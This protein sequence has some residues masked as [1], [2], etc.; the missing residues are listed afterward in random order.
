MPAGRA[1]CTLKPGD[2][3][4]EVRYKK[5]RRAEGIEKREGVKTKTQCREGR[6]GGKGEVNG[7]N[8][9]ARAQ[10]QGR[11]QGRNES[12]KIQTEKGNKNKLNARRKGRSGGV[13]FLGLLL[14][15]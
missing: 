6:G 7:T 1:S 5:R 9:R 12:R 3:G 4:R 15:G 14:A 13:I 2:G 10:R 11:K 8:E